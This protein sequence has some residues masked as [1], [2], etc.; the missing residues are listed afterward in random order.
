MNESTRSTTWP[1]NYFRS[2]QRSLPKTYSNIRSCRIQLEHAFLSAKDFYHCQFSFSG[3]TDNKVAW[4][5][6]AAGHAK[7]LL[8]KCNGLKV[9][10]VVLRYS[11][12]GG[13]GKD[14]H[15]G[16][17]DH[18]NGNSTMLAALLSNLKHRGPKQNKN[19]SKWIVHCKFPRELI[20]H[21]FKWHMIESN[22]FGFLEFCF[23]QNQSSQ[24]G[25]F[26]Q[27]QICT[28]YLPRFALKPLLTWAAYTQRLYNHH[29][30]ST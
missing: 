2:L 25:K 14:N 6:H 12:S 28:N 29:W 21:C 5:S 16:N 17:N 11:F 19:S 1:K 20:A 9:S 30:A 24:R 10:S 15:Q 3:C 8:K 23:F 22:C 26:H 4:Q 27:T 13:G 7:C 18:E